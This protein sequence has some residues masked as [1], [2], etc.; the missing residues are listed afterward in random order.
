MANEDEMIEEY[1]LDCLTD[2]ELEEMQE[3]AERIDSEKV[4]RLV[5]GYRHMRDTLIKIAFSEKGAIPAFWEVYQMAL[6]TD[7]SADLFKAGAKRTLKGM[8]DMIDGWKR[9]Q[10]KLDE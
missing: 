4:L 10:G 9:L 3:V 1:D 2:S 6:G 8:D 7:N 5:R